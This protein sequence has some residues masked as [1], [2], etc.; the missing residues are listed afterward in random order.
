[1]FRVTL[2]SITPRSERKQSKIKTNRRVQ[3]IY[4][5]FKNQ[6]LLTQPGFGAVLA[7]KRDVIFWCLFTATRISNDN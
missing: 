5:L 6:R 3:I 1:M 2:V 4:E 7:V